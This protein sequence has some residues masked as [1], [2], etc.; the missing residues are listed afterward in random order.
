MFA[1]PVLI[2]DKKKY[3]LLYKRCTFT[4][5]TKS[6]KGI[7]WKCTASKTDD[8]K[9]FIT[10]DDNLNVVLKKG[11]H[12]H[13]KPLLKTTPKHVYFTCDS[14]SKAK[15]AVTPKPKTPKK[16][17]EGK[18]KKT[19]EE[20]TTKAIT[21]SDDF[22]SRERGTIQAITSTPKKSTSNQKISEKSKKDRSLDNDDQIEIKSPKKARS[23]SGTSEN[24]VKDFN[25]FKSKSSL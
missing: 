14:E 24:Y 6:K 8:C 16:F 13:K 25:L 7:V 15:K 20:N 22:E 1:G 12:T 9:V 19:P 10:T 17:K 3:M 5:R 21:E 4:R 2:R 23:A 18:S 11:K